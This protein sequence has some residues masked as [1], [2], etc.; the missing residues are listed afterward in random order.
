MGKISGN[1][2]QNNSLNGIEIGGSCFE[3]QEGFLLSFFPNPDFPYVRKGDLEIPAFAT[4]EIK[5][6][7]MVK[8]LG[9]A[10]KIKG[11]LENKATS[12]N[13]AIFTSLYD[14]QNGKDT[15]NDGSQTQPQKGDWKGIEIEPGKANLENIK[16]LYAF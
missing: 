7:A 1:F 3:F 10:L 15:N 9:G 5:E 13:P 6:G 14:D 8:F 4:L 16:I 11:N 12:Q 2:G